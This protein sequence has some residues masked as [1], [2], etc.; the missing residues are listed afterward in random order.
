MG[1]ARR[2]L[3]TIAPRSGL[4][5]RAARWVAG[6]CIALAALPAWAET[7]RLSAGDLK[8]YTQAFEA[9]D[10]GDWPAA[11][12]LAAMGYDPLPAKVITWLD[13]SRDNG[14]GNWREAARFAEQNPTWPGLTSLRLRV[15]TQMPR[16]LPPAEI[17]A[18]FD[19]NTPLTFDAV[20]LY[21]DALEALG[22]QADIAALARDRWPSMALSGSQQDRFLAR[23]ADALGGAERWARLDNL[24]WQ[25]RFDE[26]RRMLPLVD[27][28]RR[29]LADARMRLAGQ[30]NGVDAAIGRVPAHLENDEGLIFER[31][32]WRRRA[33]MTEDAI[34]LLAHQPAAVNRPE[35]WWTERAIL[36]RRLFND[37]D[38]AGTYAVASDHRQTD[39]T[40]L[41]EAEW[42][43]GWV[44]L[45][46]LD[47]PSLAVGHFQ[48][49]YDAVSTP[50]SLARGAY[51]L[52]RAY[53][54]DGR[55]A[56]ATHWY[57]TAA[58]YDSVFYGQLAAGEIGLPTVSSLVPSPNLPPEAVAA[59]E[60][61]ELAQVVHVMVQLG[62]MDRAEQFL[63]RLAAQHD[64]PISRVMTSR[65]AL[66]LGEQQIAVRLAKQAL[67]DGLLLTDA[68][69][70]MQ[71][72]DTADRR[73][74]PALVLG[75]IRQES[76]FNMRAVSGSG[77]LGLMQLMPA[78]ADGVAR[79]LGVRHTARRLT[80]DASHN[81]HLG[82]VYLADQIERF[83]GSYVMAIAGYN[84]GPNRIASWVDKLGDPRGGAMGLYRVI[85]WIEAIPVPET[86][87]Y[88]QRVLENT[89]VY[90]LRLGAAPEIGGL[91]KDLLR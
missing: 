49:M 15:E 85:D 71:P 40:T 22:R 8:L 65:L 7:T 75:L 11:R 64:D 68:A 52:G 4:A 12:R 80:E 88:V 34:A 70:P 59:F 74:D 18:W 83:R 38:Y 56:E 48:R 2:K 73:V 79:K 28:E 16:N 10:R 45:R 91:E 72:I 69:F 3:V 90:R 23:F 47:E 84:A 14:G 43:A 46:F 1:Q 41:S 62:Q 60:R 55:T 26:A 9:V 78:T 19:A 51:W 53:M 5:K 67:R 82:S 36:A 32:R 30:R 44:A 6:L 77:A 86:R 33:D 42:L 35:A 31:V 66:S 63:Q 20:M 13:L 39:P 61:N 50:V 57:R 29:A 17:A 76:E 21:A 58:Q 27:P 25:G 81:V 24:L 89:Q 54:A 37:G 87:N